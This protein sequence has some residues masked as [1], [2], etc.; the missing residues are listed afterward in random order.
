MQK[1]PL[2]ILLALLL[3]SC[4]AHQSAISD[5]RSDVVKVQTH[6]NI[7]LSEPSLQQVRAE[8]QRDCRD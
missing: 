6:Q 5:I 3:A 7:F 1:V 8:T 2:C 4:A